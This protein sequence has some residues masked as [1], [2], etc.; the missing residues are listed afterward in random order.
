MTLPD[1]PIFVMRD[2][3][4]DAAEFES[5]LLNLGCKPAYAK[6]AAT[7]RRHRTVQIRSVLDGNAM[8]SGRFV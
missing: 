4:E 1:N 5:K 3:D 8:L 6:R 2:P 7:E